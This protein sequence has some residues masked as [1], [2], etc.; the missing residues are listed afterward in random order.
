MMKTT[1][2]K[3]VLSLLLCVM[4][5]AAMALSFNGCNDNKD[6]TSAPESVAVTTTTADATAPTAVG[7]GA[8]TFTFTAYD[9]EGKTTVFA[10]STDKTTVGEALVDAGII[11]GDPSDYGLFVKTVNGITLDYNKDGQ[12]WSFL[13]NGEYAQTGVDSTNIEANT[14]YSFK[15]AK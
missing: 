12:Y 7:Q 14:E 15:P 6:T 2:C 8:T 1:Q 5:I 4:L 9:L 3:H 10:V 13:I 11:A